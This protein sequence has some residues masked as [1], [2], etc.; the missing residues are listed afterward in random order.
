LRVGIAGT[1]AEPEPC[2]GRPRRSASAT[3]PRT[4]APDPG[5]RK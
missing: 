1:E 2:R 4:H 5:P 3:G